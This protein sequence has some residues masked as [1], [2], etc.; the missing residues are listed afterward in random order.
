[1]SKD[2]PLSFRVLQAHAV[3]LDVP[4]SLCAAQAVAR[5]Q[6]E[7]GVQGE[8][9]ARISFSVS[10]TLRREGPPSKS[11]GLL[12]VLVGQIFTRGL[13]YLR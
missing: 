6:H 7:G 13:F 1:M 5:Q 9:A 11:E 8:E 12:S 4:A 10:S 3:V 2:L